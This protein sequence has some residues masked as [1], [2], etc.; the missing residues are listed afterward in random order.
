M[1][2]TVDF[3][4]KTKQLIDSLKGICS[5]HGLGNDGDEYK[6]IT[7]AFLYKFL[8][9]KFTQE[10]KKLKPDLAKAENW[11]EE[12]EKISDDEYELLTMQ[13][14]A[15]TAVFYP[16]HLIAH[17]FAEQNKSDFSKTFDD[18]LMDIAKINNDIFAVT[19]VGGAKET[20]F[21][22]ISEIVDKSERNDFCKA[23]I[24]KLMEFSFEH[25]FHE[26][27]DFYAEI[28]QYLIKDYNNDSG[29]TYAEYYTPHTVARIMA[30]ILVTEEVQ[31]V[32]C[33]DPSAG[34]GTLL[35]NLAHAIGEDKCSIYSQDVSKKSSKL[36][37]LNL[38]LN[39]LVH[40]LQN[41]VR[42]NT[43]LAPFHKDAEGNLQK[44]DYIVSNPPFKLDFS[45]DRDAIDTKINRDRFFA[46]VPKIPKKDK[47]GMAIYT[48]F[49]QH[50][51]HSLS[52]KGKAAIVV[53][54]GFLTA[55]TGIDK[56]I[57]EE[58]IRQKMLA[59]VITMPPNIFATTGTNVSIIFLDR[60]N[61]GKIVLMDASNL[62]KTVKE[63]K[64]QRT[65]LTGVEEDKIIKTFNNKTIIEGFTVVVDYK[66]IKAKKLSLSAGQYFDVKIEYKNISL[67][68][69]QAKLEKHKT[70]LNGYFTESEMLEEQI[71]AQLKGLRI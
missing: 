27:Y 58:L 45:K 19:A 46:G 13:I 38:I 42:G 49:F 47:K 59:G 50:I 2:T 5:S 16:R 17:L 32:T 57:R 69:F 40:S 20:L 43:I 31:N 51:M 8:N 10:L 18:T 23:I 22:R 15:D 9:D 36:L 64:N 30:N 44:F 63:G 29:G 55:K 12:V 7:Q 34:S 26:K 21:E 39:N 37:R 24:N 62:G 53:P 66:D 1:T 35:M 48:L 52:A 41:I 25:I 33:Y 68:E 60:S 11:Q 65:I 3:Q 28:F 70:T 4:N 54:K 56:K 71:Q 61:E 6:V 67:D 14:E